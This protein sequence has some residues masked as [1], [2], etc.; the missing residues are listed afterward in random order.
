MWC[1]LFFGFTIPS[2]IT[3]L[4][5]YSSSITKT[6]SCKQQD[7]FISLHRSFISFINHLGK[8]VCLLCTLYQRRH[9]TNDS[10]RSNRTLRRKE[11][12]GSYILPSCARGSLTTSISVTWWWWWWWLL[13]V[14]FSQHLSFISLVLREERLCIY[15]YIFES[16]NCKAEKTRPTVPLHGTNGTV[17]AAGAEK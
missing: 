2:L 6:K 8:C 5:Y 7:I 10:S 16:S 13:V 12:G 4:L 1:C 14:V 3:L 15:I 17:P 11:R 9:I